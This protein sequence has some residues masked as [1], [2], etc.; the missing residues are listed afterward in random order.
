MILA[1]GGRHG[2]TVLDLRGIRGGRVS[3]EQA[4]AAHGAA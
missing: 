1:P 4:Q 3:P 2:D